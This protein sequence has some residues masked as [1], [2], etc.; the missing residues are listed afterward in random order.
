MTDDRP[1]AQRGLGLAQGPSYQRAWNADTV[2]SVRECL[3][4]SEAPRRYLPPEKQRCPGLTGQDHFPSEYGRSRRALTDPGPPQKE[5]GCQ[6]GAGGGQSHTVVWTLLGSTMALLPSQWSPV[7]CHSIRIL[8][9]PL[10]CASHAPSSGHCGKR[11]REG[12][13]PQGP[14]LF[15]D[16]DRDSGH[17]PHRHSGHNPCVDPALLCAK[18]RT[19]RAAHVSLS[20]CLKCPLF[21]FY[22]RDN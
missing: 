4:P 7:S 20:S 21:P 19:K 9:G 3:M 17:H 15:R 2:C 13:H 6:A 18:P 14:A 8:T 22:R 5:P 12:S 11:R 1:K 10:P 16:N